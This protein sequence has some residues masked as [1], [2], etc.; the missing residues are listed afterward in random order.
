MF[1]PPSRTTYYGTIRV[2]RLFPSGALYISA[3]RRGRFCEFK[4]LGY[5]VREAL[6]LFREEFPAR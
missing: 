6:A 4:Y 5:T 2:D 3:T 1:D